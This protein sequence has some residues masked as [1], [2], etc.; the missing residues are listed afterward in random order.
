MTTATNPQTGE[1]V[2]LVGSEWKPVEQTA[3]NSNG[4]KAYLVGNSWIEDKESKYDPSVSDLRYQVSRAQKGAAGLLALPAEAVYHGGQLLRRGLSN[5]PG[6]TSAVPELPIESPSQLSRR[7]LGGPEIKAPSRTAEILGG[8]SEFAGAGILPSAAVV[9]RAAHKIPALLSEAGSTVLGGVGSEVAGLPGALAG[10]AVGMQTPL[11]FSKAYSLVSGT[12]PWLSK[13][14][15]SAAPKE[16]I[17]AIQ[18]HPEA[19]RNVAMADEVTSNLARLRAGEFRP[20]LAG[21]TG[22]PGIIAREQQ[23]AGSSPGE[24]SRYTA[25]QSENLATVESAQNIAFPKGGDIPRAAESLRLS[26]SRELEKRLDVINRQRENLTRML[27]SGGQQAAGEKLVEL[28]DKAQAVAR[29]VVTTKR[30]DLYA[31]ADRLKI[32]EPMDDVLAKVREVGGSDQNIF[33]NMPPVFGKIINRYAAKTQELT[34]RSIDPELMAAKASEAAPKPATFQEIH[35]LWREANTQYGAALRSGNAQAQ[36]YIQQVRDS[37]K[38]KLDKF[39][40]GGFGEVTDKFRDFNRFYATK[41]AP[42]FKEGV[43]GKLGAATRFGD[44]VK[45]EDVVSK[46]FTPSGIDDFNLIYSS[47]PQAQTALADGVV[48]LFRQ[49]AVKGGKIDQRASQAFLRNNAESLEKLPD[50]KAILSNPVA[51]NEALLE[52]GTRFKINQKE[53]NQSAVAKIANTQNAEAL[54]DKALSNTQQ[55]RQ[56][57]ALGSAGGPQSKQAVASMIAERIPEVARKAGVDPFSFV[58]QNQFTLKPALDQL[59][60]NHFN[61]LRT[62]AGART[63]LGRTQLPT[64]VE[65]GRIKD[66]AEQITGTGAPSLISQARATFITR[67]SSP[68]YM[69]SLALSKFGI[70]LREEQT[71]ALIK[72]AIYNPETASA[73]AKAAHTGKLT[74]EESNRLADH[75][76]S[77][78][79]RIESGQE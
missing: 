34:G 23:V 7:T 46:F 78:G 22:A 10:S 11:A 45:P 39:E 55:M 36:Y 64:T 61:N 30:D 31:T 53:F 62:I 28:R 77:A 59:G 73:W 51:T 68:M 74:F 42:A 71:Q 4:V 50:I 60:P 67:Q 21:K 5:I 72:E 70:K 25:R 76:L 79:I 57:V 2:V 12:V 58:V 19:G 38:A 6:Y 43:G 3:T 18:A 47:N 29:Q 20:T 75:L 37:L 14:Y 1:T 48:G 24:L 15:S 33:Q 9:G 27:P 65:A 41:Y 17:S 56:L 69:L 44:L 49:A 26:V 13:Q 35:S 8:A 63:V 32:S 66:I 16:L 54:V 40:T 52:A